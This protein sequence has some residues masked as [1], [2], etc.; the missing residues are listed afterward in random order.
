MKAK[1]SSHL[2]TNRADTFAWVVRVSAHFQSKGEIMFGQE[3]ITTK[4]REE[5][6]REEMIAARM[7]SF[8]CCLAI[9]AFETLH[10]ALLDAYEALP[11]LQK[12]QRPWITEDIALGYFARDK[13][14]EDSEKGLR[15]IAH[16]LPKLILIAK[17]MRSAV[18]GIA[19]DVR[20]EA[21]KCFDV[22]FEATDVGWWLNEI[23]MDREWLAAREQ[24]VRNG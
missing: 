22:D 17:G 5:R 2:S 13:D 24:G 11:A 15:E 14:Q 16:D 10:K 8:D 7:Y 1:G 3:P 12:A 9:E 21:M 19:M 20:K 4:M 23:R 6:E 18:Y